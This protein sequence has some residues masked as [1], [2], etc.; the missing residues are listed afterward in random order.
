MSDFRPPRDDVRWLLRFGLDN[1]SR[2]PSYTDSEGELYDLFIPR[3]ILKI[4][5]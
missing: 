3:N 2:F 1:G 5:Y 4:I